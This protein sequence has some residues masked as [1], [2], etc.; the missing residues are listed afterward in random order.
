[1]VGPHEKKMVTSEV[2]GNIAH[3]HQ[4]VLSNRITMLRIQG[5]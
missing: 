3:A 5:T 1:M 2:R 4:G